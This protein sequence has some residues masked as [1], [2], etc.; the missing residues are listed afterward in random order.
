MARTRLG[1]MPY[2]IVFCL[3]VVLVLL[4]SGLGVVTDMSLKG[5]DRDD[6]ASITLSDAMA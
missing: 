1:K 5:L 4:A 3:V 2:V 6:G